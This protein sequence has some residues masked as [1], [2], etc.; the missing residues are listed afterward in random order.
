MFLYTSEMY[1]KFVEMLQKGSKWR[2]LCHFGKGVD[3][4][5]ET[6]ATDRPPLD[7]RPID[8]LSTNYRRTIKVT[9]ITQMT[10]IFLKCIVYSVKCIVS[11]GLRPRV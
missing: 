3:I 9:R 4:L 5:G 11:G 6:L 1:I 7:L 10:R 8:E 2:P